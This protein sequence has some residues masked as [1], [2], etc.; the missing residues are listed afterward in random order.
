M[1]SK[2]APKAVKE[3]IVPELLDAD[4]QPIT[5]VDSQEYIGDYKGFALVKQQ[6]GIPH[7][8]VVLHALIPDPTYPGRFYRNWLQF[9]YKG[10]EVGQEIDAL[11]VAKKYIDAYEVPTSAPFPITK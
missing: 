6:T 10:A 11:A 4:N 5:L 7:D 3:L 8:P 2:K 1:D 9:D